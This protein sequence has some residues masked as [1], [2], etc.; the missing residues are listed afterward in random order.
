LQD[1]AST[2][3]K[4][5]PK[6]ICAPDNC[7]MIPGPEECHEKTMVSTI[8]KPSEICD[9]QPQRHC[10]L[11]TRLVPHLMQVSIMRLLNSQLQRQFF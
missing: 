1:K 7:K 8:E 2:W 4:K 6:K 5:V 3:C 11:I 9:L 10:R